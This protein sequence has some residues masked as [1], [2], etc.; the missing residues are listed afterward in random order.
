[1]YICTITQ[2]FTRKRICELLGPTHTHPY[3]HTRAY[4]GQCGHSELVGHAHAHTIHAY[5]QENLKIGELLGRRV[6][7][8]GIHMHPSGWVLASV[9]GRS[10]AVDLNLGVQAGFDCKTLTYKQVC[11]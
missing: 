3:T 11:A 8:F 1:M 4:T 7:A 6:T 10:L 2:T 9:G 5:I